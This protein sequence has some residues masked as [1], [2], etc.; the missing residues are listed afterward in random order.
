VLSI[1]DLRSAKSKNNNLISIHFQCITIAEIAEFILDELRET[2]T[3]TA[4][5]VRVFKEKHFMKPVY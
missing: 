2:K 5:A 3:P 1:L 4:A